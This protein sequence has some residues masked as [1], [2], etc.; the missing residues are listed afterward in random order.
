MTAK[1]AAFLGVPLCNLIIHPRNY[2]A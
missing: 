1:S 2:K